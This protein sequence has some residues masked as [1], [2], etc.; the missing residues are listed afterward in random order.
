M[1]KYPILFCLVASII[2]ITP[3]AARE[4]DETALDEKMLRN[5]LNALF[6]VKVNL[7]FVNASLDEVIT[8]L[9]NSAGVKVNLP[10]IPDFKPGKVTIV[11]RNMLLDDFLYHVL[12]PN[13]LHHSVGR[14]GYPVERYDKN[15]EPVKTHLQLLARRFP[16]VRERECELAAKLDKI[17]RNPE[18]ENAS[19]FDM[20]DAFAEKGGFSFSI[21]PVVKDE[22]GVLVGKMPAGEMGFAGLEKFLLKKKEL[23]IAVM[24]GAVYVSRANIAGALEKVVEGCAA[25]CKTPLGVDEGTY[26][27]EN[28]SVIFDK[29]GLPL[30]RTD[31]VDVLPEVPVFIEKGMTVHSAAERLK[32]Q[33][34]LTLVPARTDGLQPVCVLDAPVKVSSWFE[35]LEG[36]PLDPEKADLEKTAERI[37]YL[38]KNEAEIDGKLLRN[39]TERGVVDAQLNRITGEHK[40][41]KARLLAGEFD[42]EELEKLTKE[43]EEQVKPLRARMEKLVEENNAMYREL[44][45]LQNQRA[46]LKERLRYV[47]NKLA[48]VEEKKLSSPDRGRIVFKDGYQAAS[49]IIDSADEYLVVAWILGERRRIDPNTVMAVLV[50]AGGVEMAVDLKTNKLVPKNSG[51]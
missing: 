36:M 25:V 30:Y 6:S 5:R 3:L 46:M 44:G 24:H 47:E 39:Q 29:L 35:R 13:G 33:T 19:L 8:A 26:Y 32:R 45:E 14:Y 1:Y 4:K 34:G 31:R 17:T 40:T 27:P 48:A 16:G 41:R 49:V 22:G 10:E 51:R 50:R 18:L 7:R 23:R 12:L 2:F 38:K 43:Y 11:A 42:S 9:E 21:D 37:E 15:A 28:L 20:L